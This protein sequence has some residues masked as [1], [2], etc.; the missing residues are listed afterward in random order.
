MHFHLSNPAFQEYH[1]QIFGNCPL[2]NSKPNKIYF[3]FQCRYIGYSKFLS[4]GNTLAC[5]S[6]HLTWYHIFSHLFYM[7]IEDWI[8]YWRRKQFTG[9]ELTRVNSILFI[10]KYFDIEEWYKNVAYIYSSTLITT[11][12]FDYWNPFTSTTHFV[13]PP[14]I[15]TFF[16]KLWL[17]SMRDLIRMKKGRHSQLKKKKKK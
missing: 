13:F 8:I 15:N 11:G 6:K 16:T 3:V 4:C 5:G 14:D 12:F 1:S 7:I 9:L 10:F 2:E 17:H